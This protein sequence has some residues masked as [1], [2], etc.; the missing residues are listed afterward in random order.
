M[1]DANITSWS[2]PGICQR[3][4]LADSCVFPCADID[5]LSQLVMSAL[6]KNAGVTLPPLDGAAMTE[7][8]TGECSQNCS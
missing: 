7:E 8:G 4:H 5:A 2:S 6:D 1:S 3:C